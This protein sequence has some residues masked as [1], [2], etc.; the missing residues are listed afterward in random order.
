MQIVEE[1]TANGWC[2]MKVGNKLTEADFTVVRR[3][4]ELFGTTCYVRI[5]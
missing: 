1:T 2:N 3:I 5:G 4:K